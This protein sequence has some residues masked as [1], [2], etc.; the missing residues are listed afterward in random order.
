MTAAKGRSGGTTH[1]IAHVLP[2]RLFLPVSAYES[3]WK[4]YN[5][6]DRS[7]FNIIKLKCLHFG[8]EDL[9][10]LFYMSVSK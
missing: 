6:E 5:K 10:H 2:L 1:V 4:S 8:E 3:I 9:G 7:Y